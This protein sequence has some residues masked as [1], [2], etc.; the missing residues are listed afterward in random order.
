MQTGTGKKKPVSSVKQT[1]KAEKGKQP[2]RKIYRDS[3][4]GVSNSAILRLAQKAGVLTVATPIYDETRNILSGV[5]GQILKEVTTIL[6][7][8]KRK[9]VTADDVTKACSSLY[10]K[11]VTLKKAPKRCKILESSGNKDTG[12]TKRGDFAR[13]AIDF[14]QSQGNGCVH[15]AVKPFRRLAKELSQP[16]IVDI[17]FSAE[18]LGILQT[19]VEQYIVDLFDATLLASEHAGRKSIQPRDMQLVIKIKNNC[20][21][22]N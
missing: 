13:Q 16:Y 17:L 10:I 12:V 20:N 21:S 9:T 18:S 1:K 2:L 3:I 4:Q 15:I 7:Q 22:N 11:A 5:L 19:T 14:Y 8:E 6:R